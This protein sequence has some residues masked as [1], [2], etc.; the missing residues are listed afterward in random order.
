[1]LEIADGE[2]DDDNPLPEDVTGTPHAK[3]SNISWYVLSVR[4]LGVSGGIWSMG[5]PV[6]CIGSVR[7]LKQQTP[8]Q[9][10][11]RL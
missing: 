9:L 5:R 1:M 11:Q 2:L 3:P 4:K 6:R 8:E 10:M 7:V